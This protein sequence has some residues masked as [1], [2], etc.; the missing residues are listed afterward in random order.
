MKEHQYSSLESLASAKQCMIIDNDGKGNC[1]F[2]AIAHQLNLPHVDHMAV[3]QKAVS[4]LTHNL[5]TVSLIDNNII[6][7]FPKKVD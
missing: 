3:R 7:Q 6:Y 1:Q 5:A 4:Y 2:E